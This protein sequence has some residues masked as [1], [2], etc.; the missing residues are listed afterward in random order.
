MD[1]TLK[2]LAALVFLFQTVHQL[3]AED[4]FRW[5]G[6]H[7][8]GVSEEADWTA[9][10]DGGSA[11]IAWKASVGIGF[12][13]F[14]VANDKVITMGHIDNQSVV[15]AF[16]AGDGNEIWKFRFP[17][18]LDDRDFEGGPTSTPDNRK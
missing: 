17:A 16:H 4:W 10:W 15:H 13:S 14:V 12:S 18:A 7:S 3:A 5:R 1:K 2:A 9:D 11:A 6:P 8:N